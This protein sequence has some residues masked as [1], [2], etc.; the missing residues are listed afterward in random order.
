MLVLGFN[1]CCAVGGG[2]QSGA[3]LIDICLDVGPP[4]P[5]S[6]SPTVTG[7]Q[8]GG[9][10]VGCDLWGG[11][12][13]VVGVLP[14]INIDTWGLCDCLCLALVCRGRYCLGRGTFSLFFSSFWDRVWTE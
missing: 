11:E 10:P 2:L 7:C 5:C 3:T 12:C 6:S 9:F 13:D 4:P 8:L 1:T 14:R